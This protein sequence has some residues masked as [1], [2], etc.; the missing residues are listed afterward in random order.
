MANTT[1]NKRPSKKSREYRWQ[2]LP[3]GLWTCADGRQV[4]FNRRY[5][6]LYQRS[7]NGVVSSADP[8]ERVPW[9]DELWFYSSPSSEQEK[10]R[11]AIKA[12][13]DWNLQ[14]P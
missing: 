5:R 9:K 7:P 1:A 3:Y 14:V 10:R 6:P 2:L 11:N 8:S 4:L 13:N 12:L